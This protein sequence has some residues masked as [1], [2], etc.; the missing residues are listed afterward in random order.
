MLAWENKRRNQHRETS[1]DIQDS[2]LMN[3][4]DRQ[5]RGFRGSNLPRTHDRADVNLEAVLSDS[6][7]GNH[8]AETALNETTVR[9]WKI[10]IVAT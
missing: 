4:T 3:L 1:P 10:E 2:E 8:G 6:I 5:N 7:A 9:V